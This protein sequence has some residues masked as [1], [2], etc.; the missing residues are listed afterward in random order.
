MKSIIYLINCPFDQLKL[1]IKAEVA[2][3]NHQNFL[4]L[5]YICAYL[6]LVPPN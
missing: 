4:V 6:I 3:T 5:N 2:V 1:L